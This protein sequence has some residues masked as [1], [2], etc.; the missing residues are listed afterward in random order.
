MTESGGEVTMLLAEWKAGRREALDRLLPL[1][2]HELR[3]QA[4]YYMQ[5]ERRGHTLQPTA[6]VHEA[7]VR[8][9]GQDRANWQNRA[10]FMSIAGQ[11]MRRILVDYARKRSTAKRAGTLVT[12]DE[13]IGTQCADV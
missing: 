12:L 13:A 7:F 9:T 6:L 10:Q 3:R 8:L 1:V 11:L 4:D 5:A 2:Y